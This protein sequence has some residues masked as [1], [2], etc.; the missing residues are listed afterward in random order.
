MKLR[1]RLKNILEYFWDW[2][3]FLHL[4]SPGRPDP[5]H[6]QM[7][8]NLT[9]QSSLCTHKWPSSSHCQSV[10][11]KWETGKHMLQL[12]ASLLRKLQ[13]LYIPSS[14]WCILICGVW[15]ESKPSKP[16]V[17]QDMQ[18]WPIKGCH[19]LK[20]SV[21]FQGIFDMPGTFLNIPG[22]VTEVAFNMPLWKCAHKHTYIYIYTHTYVNVPSMLYLYNAHRTAWIFSLYT[23]LLCSA[24]SDIPVDLWKR[25][26]ILP[27]RFPHP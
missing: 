11:R 2:S 24:E 15:L 13:L 1:E 19:C 9:L 20:S 25:Q 18:S 8:N 26:R 17:K 4:R 27:V 5:V 3:G 10:I 23:W 21:S 6:V 16:I 14:P 7:W 22:T 12:Q